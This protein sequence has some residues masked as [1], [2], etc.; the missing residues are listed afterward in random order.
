MQGEVYEIHTGE[1]KLSVCLLARLSVCLSLSAARF[2]ATP[3]PRR[4][5]S[6]QQVTLSVPGSASLQGESLLSRVRIDDDDFQG[7]VCPGLS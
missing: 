5:S 3:D 2:E 6:A 7:T 4:P 1:Y